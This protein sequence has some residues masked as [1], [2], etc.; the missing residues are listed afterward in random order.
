VH[1][2]FITPGPKIN[3]S[4]PNIVACYWF[5]F[6]PDMTKNLCPWTL[7]FVFIY[8]S[9]ILPGKLTE[10]TFSFAAMTWGIVTG[11]RRG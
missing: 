1:W 4:E 10:N 2:A 9:I 3:K 8:L 7:K 11:E 6:G 5:R